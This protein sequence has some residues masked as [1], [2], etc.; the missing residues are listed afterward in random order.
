M[1]GLFGKPKQSQEAQP[2]SRSNP[3]KLTEK[4]KAIL[5][6]KRMRDRLRKYRDGLENIVKRETSIARELLNKG[7]K[8]KAVLVLKKK[9]HQEG[10]VEKAMGQLANLETMMMDIETAALNKQI[11]DAMDVSP[12]RITIT[13]CILTRHSLVTPVA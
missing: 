6:L 5:E 1:G 8:K 9:K 4:D 10:L 7:E 2:Q 12:S 3:S 11:I 13:F